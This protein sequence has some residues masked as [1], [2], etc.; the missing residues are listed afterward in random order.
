MHNI[1]HCLIIIVLSITTITL[2]CISFSKTDDKAGAIIPN[3][4]AYPLYKYSKLIDQT[5][6]NNVASILLNQDPAI[7]TASLKEILN[8]WELPYD[9]IA[10]SPATIKTDWLLWHYDKE[11]QTSYS[12]PEIHFLTLNVEDRYRFTFLVEPYGQNQTRI[13]LTQVLRE[14]QKD[15][16]PGSTYVWLKWEPVKENPHAV[17][18]FLVRL[19]TEFERIALSDQLSSTFA[20]NV[21]PAIVVSETATADAKN[22]LPLN[23]S[24][25]TAWSQLILSLSNKNIALETVDSEQHTIQTKWL[26]VSYDKI[27]K[28]LVFNANNGEQ[29]KFKFIVTPGSQE[30]QSTIF[31]YQTAKK[32]NNKEITKAQSN[33]QQADISAEFLNYLQLE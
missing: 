12:K 25:N 29:Y 17:H 18:D 30:N 33:N 20:N 13:S 1:K 9:I 2:P 24:V 3:I 15:I 19:Q 11:T 10:E 23:A 31:V 7:N 27:N 26:P 14:I 16:T 28:A 32:Q 8:S 21:K 22:Y 6:N 5:T 4:A